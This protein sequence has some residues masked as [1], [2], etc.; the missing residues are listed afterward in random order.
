MPVYIR[1]L[2]V[3]CVDSCAKKYTDCEAMSYTS[4]EAIHFHASSLFGDAAAGLVRGK[5]CF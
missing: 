3:A 1:K 4:K 5:P 2:T